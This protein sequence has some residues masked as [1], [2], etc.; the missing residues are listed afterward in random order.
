LI[1]SLK[2]IGRGIALRSSAVRVC[3]DLPPAKL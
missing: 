3:P 2:A 1:P